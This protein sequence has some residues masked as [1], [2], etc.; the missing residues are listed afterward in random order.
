MQ[1]SKNDEIKMR[2]AYGFFNKNSRFNGPRYKRGKD[3]I[4]STDAIKSASRKRMLSDNPAKKPANRKRMSEANPNVYLSG[5][6]TA[7]EQSLTRKAETLVKKQGGR[8]Q[9]PF[10]IFNTR[11]DF[12]IKHGSE[13]FI[14]RVVKNPDYVPNIKEVKLSKYLKIEDLGKSYREMGWYITSASAS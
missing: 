2:H 7:Q 8:I 14:T 13:V 1:T 10:G 5:D 3:N 4:F 6:K 12:Y 11:K 9:T